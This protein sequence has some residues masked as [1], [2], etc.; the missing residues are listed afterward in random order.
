[1]CVLNLGGGL[2]A[3]KTLVT[4]SP[5]SHAGEYNHPHAD[6]E[7]SSGMRIS[8]LANFLEAHFGDIELHMPDVIDEG[9][10]EKRED[11]DGP[12]FLVRLDEA[13]A[14]INLLT[15]VNILNCAFGRC[16][17]LT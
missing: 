6:G 12:S 13:D 4:S 11:E 14:R 1:M 7:S 2:G 3:D 15:L 9:N 17:H 10:P 5:H 8:R 16:F